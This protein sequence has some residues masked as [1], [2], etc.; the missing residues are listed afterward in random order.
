MVAKEH[1]ELFAV[2]R[3][4]FLLIC[5]DFPVVKTHFMAIAKERL[6]HTAKLGGRVGAVACKFAR[7]LQV[8][9]PRAT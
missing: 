2:E 9:K 5:K 8:S 6:A 3:K 1:C 4:N 7:R